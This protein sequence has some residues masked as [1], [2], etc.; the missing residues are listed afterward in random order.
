[1]LVF[2]VLLMTG[3]YVLSIPSA[4]WMWIRSFS[5]SDDHENEERATKYSNTDAP[6]EEKRFLH[7]NKILGFVKRSYKTI[8]TIIGLNSLN[9]K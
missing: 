5:Q 9:A 7:Y 3:D 8:Y 4:R 2:I 6:M 1:M